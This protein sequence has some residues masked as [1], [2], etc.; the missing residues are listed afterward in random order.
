MKT[1]SQ[2]FQ[3][4]RFRIPLALSVAFL[5]LVQ[6]E[7]L[8]QDGTPDTGFD[9]DGMVITDFGSPDEVCRALA[10]QSDGKIVAAGS[11]QGSTHRIVCLARYNA[12]G[13]LD[14]GFDGDGKAEY[15]HGSNIDI[16]DMQLQ[17]DGKILLVGGYSSND[18]F[19]AR[20]NTDGSLDTSFNTDGILEPDLGGL[21][22][23]AFSVLLQPDQKIVIGAY[24]ALSASVSFALARFLPNGA[25]DTSFN[26]TGINLNHFNSQ[27]AI[28]RSICLQP[29]GKIVAAGSRANASNNDILLVRYQANG[30]LDSSFGNS[31][32]VI[33]DLGAWEAAYSVLVEPDGK[34]L[35]AASTGTTWSD[36]DFVCLRFLADGSPDL[37]FNGTGY[38]ITNMGGADRVHSVQRLHSG[39]I[40]LGGSDGNGKFAL[41][42][43]LSNGSL[44]LSFNSTGKVLTNLGFSFDMILQ[45]DGKILMGGFKVNGPQSEFGLIRYQQSNPLSLAENGWHGTAPAFPNPSSGLLELVSETAAELQV[46]ELSGKCLIKMEIQEGSNRIDLQ[47]LP[48]GCYVLKQLHEG[49]QIG[50]YK[51]IRE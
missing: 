25:L 5:M 16:H 18:L 17:H 9:Q 36:E 14:T 7:G 2:R 26:H 38:V 46:F 37:S 23:T 12:D 3:R 51:W 31:G 28:V 15:N 42:R 1:P 22:E 47:A 45:Q 41:A 19:M 30:T 13:S 4:F 48:S 29:D 50:I 43:Y 39:K 24:S 11:Y 33:K 35:L 8:S 40:L 27:S 32:S 21:N 34:L 49:Q 44:D 10:Q 6:L 20:F